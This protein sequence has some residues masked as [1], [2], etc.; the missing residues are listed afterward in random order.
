M[1]RFLTAVA[2]ALLSAGMAAAADT[3]GKVTIRWHGQSFFDIQSSKGTRIVIDPHAIEAYGRQTVGA[4]LILISHFHTD[5]TQVATVQDHAKA[6]VL[7]GLKGGAKRVDWNPIDETFRDVHVRTVGVYH[8]NV[9]GMERG[10]NAIFIVEVDGLRIVHLGDLGHLLSAKEIKSIGSV[11]VLMIPVG[12][13]YTINGSEAQKVVEQLK[14]KQYIL[15]MHYGTKVFDDLLPPD[16]FLED[17]KNVKRYPTSRITV[18][19]GAQ[20]A[21]PIIAL[22]DWKN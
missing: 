13:V 14:P 9:E 18:E 2:A 5:H 6:K 10:K 21:A 4:D 15:P 19:A 16:E 22:L 17:Q 3:P 11:D 7:Y 8:D 1:F 12:G 20:M